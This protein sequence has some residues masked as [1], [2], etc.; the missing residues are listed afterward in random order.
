MLVAVQRAANPGAPQWLEPFSSYLPGAS[1]LVEYHL[2]FLSILHGPH[3]IPQVLLG[4]LKDV[5]AIVNH[6]FF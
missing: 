3:I 4:L 6:I 5:L 1:H 2:H